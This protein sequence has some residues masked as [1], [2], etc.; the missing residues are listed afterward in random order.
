MGTGVALRRSLSSFHLL[1][2]VSK[3]NTYKEQGGQTPGPQQ[4]GPGG[5]VKGALGFH[6]LSRPEDVAKDRLLLRC[7]MF[8]FTVMPI[9]FLKKFCFVQ[10]IMSKAGNSAWLP[11]RKTVSQREGREQQVERK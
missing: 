9:V 7:L 8:R 10:D 1:R 2:D 5:A 4:E 11:L 3:I 6:T